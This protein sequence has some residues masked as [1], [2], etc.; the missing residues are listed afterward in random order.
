MS[1]EFCPLVLVLQVNPENADTVVCSNQISTYITLFSPRNLFD[2]TFKKLN[3]L[4]RHQTRFSRIQSYAGR[5]KNIKSRFFFNN[6][7]NSAHIEKPTNASI[8]RH[9]LQTG[10]LF[11]TILR[12]SLRPATLLKK[13]LWYKCFPVNFA[14]ISKNTIFY[15]TPPV[16]ASEHEKKELKELSK[17]VFHVYKYINLSFTQISSCNIRYYIEFTQQTKTSTTGKKHNSNR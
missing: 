7:E 17:L 13:R 10:T 9:P 15:R 1:S 16:A 2:V 4:G 3:T 12:S 8:I 6:P 14:K 11:L 5:L